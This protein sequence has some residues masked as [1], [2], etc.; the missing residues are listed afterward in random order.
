LVLGNVGTN[1][2][3]KA[4]EKEPLSI[5]YKDFD[6]NG[7]IDPLFCYYINGTSYPASSRDDLTEQLPGLKKK[8]LEYRTYATATIADVFTPEELKDAGLLKAEITASVYLQNNGVAGF[9]V[10][11]LPLEMQYAPVYAMAAIDANGDG[12]QD[13]VAA[14]NNIWSRIKFGRYSANHGMVFTGD[15]KGNFAYA[16]QYTSGLN[17]S[18]QVRSLQAIETGKKM[19][20][21]FGLN[22][23]P[24]QT[25]KVNK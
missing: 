24:V 4:S 22:N 1:A 2:Q 25:Y 17:I 8:F 13:I 18:G 5:Y 7:S 12:K 9:T 15:G 11:T 23:A 16:P 6:S 10:K 21:I 20:L 19:Q 14:G 3:F